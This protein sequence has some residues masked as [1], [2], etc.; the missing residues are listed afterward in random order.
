MYTCLN[1]TRTKS[2]RWSGVHFGFKSDVYSTILHIRQSIVWYCC[3]LN[4]NWSHFF[5][6]L[7]YHLHQFICYCTTLKQIQYVLCSRCF[8][9]FALSLS[10]TNSILNAIQTSMWCAGRHTMNTLQ[11]FI[12]F[13]YQIHMWLL[14][15]NIRTCNQDERFF[16]LKRS[17]LVFRCC[18]AIQSM[19]RSPDIRF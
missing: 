11:N 14:Y 13:W 7:F 9:L 1:R 10:F 5:S 2:I 16:W 19:N 6:K 18:C 8:F 12:W 4:A 15:K 3:S 17:G